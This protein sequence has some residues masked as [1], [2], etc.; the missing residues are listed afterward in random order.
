[1]VWSSSYPDLSKQLKQ[2]C[3]DLELQGITL[4]MTRHSRPSID[5][6]FVNRTAQEVRKKGR[7]KSSKSVVGHEKAGQLARAWFTLM[8]MQRASMMWA[9]QH[10]DSIMLRRSFAL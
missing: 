3:Q 10:I 7:W 2:A 1:M 9:R 8:P 5:R 4:Y 6:A